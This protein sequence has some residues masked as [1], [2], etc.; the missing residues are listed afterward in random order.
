[1]LPAVPVT[2]LTWDRESCPTSDEESGEV[3]VPELHLTV[4][5]LCWV[6]DTEKRWGKMDHGL[7]L[8]KVCSGLTFTGMKVRRKML[9]VREKVGMQGSDKFLSGHSLA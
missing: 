6:R 8:P 1:M 4:Q 7:K 9:E 3:V 2:D 5:E